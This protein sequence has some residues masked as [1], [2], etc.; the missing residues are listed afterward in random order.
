MFGSNSF[1][2]RGSTDRNARLWTTERKFVG[3]FGQERR[4]NLRN[5]STYSHHKNLYSR[6]QEER[7]GNKKKRASAKQPIFNDGQLFNTVEP[8][9]DTEQQI[10]E[11][12]KCESSEENTKNSKTEPK[13]QPQESQLPRIEHQQAAPIQTPSEEMAQS[14]PM[15]PQLS[16]IPAPRKHESIFKHNLE[17]GL[18]KRIAQR[19]VRRRVFGEINTKK[20]NQFG[21][22]CSAFHALATT[23]MQN[24]TL[25]SDLPMT[26]RMKSKGIVCT[27][28][29]DLKSLQLIFPELDEEST[30]EPRPTDRK[31][32]LD[33]TKKPTLPPLVKY[34]RSRLSENKKTSGF[35]LPSVPTVPAS[36][37]LK[38]GKY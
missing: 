25:P 18:L 9:G 36:I 5:L 21:T 37:S 8:L 3:T 2:L 7:K 12:A 6:L 16:S 28:E 29:S 4:W 10:A 27:S 13:D 33:Q 24:L 35:R 19:N 38:W 26:P 15:A 30:E 32:P 20:V 23:E 14:W 22:A 17:E 31:K 11:K 1:I 34:S